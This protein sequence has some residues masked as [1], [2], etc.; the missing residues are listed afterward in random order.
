MAGFIYP[1][2]M[3]LI[4]RF[5]LILRP[6]EPFVHWANAPEKDPGERVTLEEVREDPVVYLIPDMEWPEATM[7]W[8]FEN[9][10]YFF[11]N[12][13][14]QYWTD[15]ELWPTNRSVEMFKEWFDIEI[16]SVLDNVVD[17]AIEEDE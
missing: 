6:K 13:L 4:N 10:D 15:E 3:G 8:V 17:E 12:Q 1:V 9:F 7:D 11:K 5:A 14:A 2:P 16:L